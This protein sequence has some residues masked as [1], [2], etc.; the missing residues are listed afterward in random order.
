MSRSWEMANKKLLEHISIFS[1]DMST[2]SLS[3]IIYLYIIE[4]VSVENPNVVLNSP[5]KARRGL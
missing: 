2:G 3:S 4:D 1:A 5:L